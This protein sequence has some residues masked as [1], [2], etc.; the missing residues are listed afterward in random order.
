[1]LQ[2]R[3]L[4]YYKAA[5]TDVACHSCNNRFKF[6]SC[7]TNLFLSSSLANLTLHCRKY[8]LTIVHCKKS[9]KHT[10]VIFLNFI[11]AL[12]NGSHTLT[13]DVQNNFREH[14][15]KLNFRISV[16]VRRNNNHLSCTFSRNYSNE[17]N[18]ANLSSDRAGG[19]RQKNIFG[20]LLSCSCQ[21]IQADHR[22]STFE[23]HS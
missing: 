2:K 18:S 6:A 3:L 22:Y 4:L 16:N 12:W 13:R 20:W 15:R 10:V 17:F 19:D 14:L 8:S 1:M 21:I 11:S 23:Y 9:R 5:L 7:L